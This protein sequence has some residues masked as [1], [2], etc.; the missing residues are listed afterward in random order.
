MRR[1]SAILI[2]LLVLAV[3]AQAA[4]NRL[5]DLASTESVLRWINTYRA[6]PEPA[7]VPDAIKALSRFGAFKEPEQ[8]GAYVGF[9]AG[10][11]AANPDKA[12]A[13]I[14]KML[15]LPPGDQWVIVRAIAYSGHPEW[16]NL[17]RRFAG[18]LPARKVMIDKYL[19]GSLPTL[20]QYTPEPYVST[21][22]SMKNKITGAEL[23]KRFILEPS[24]E[25]LD[26]YWGHYFAT[27]QARPITRIIDM[28]PMAR[29]NDSVERLTVGSMAKFTLASNATRDPELLEILKQAK[30][31]RPKEIVTQL[32]EVIDAAETVET[33]RLRKEAMAA[34]EELRR[35]GPGSRRNIS[36]AGQVGQGALALGCIAAA[37]TGHIE[38]GL[39]CVIGGGVSSAALSAWEKQQ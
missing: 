31:H 3:P 17:L 19:A 21:W 28:L 33:A 24:P 12:E 4:F 9:L 37:A 1:A 15:P 6:K 27:G 29:D 30:E 18:R 7:G 8:A 38:L 26:T 5:I 11:V 10:V 16:R 35:K 36:I 14:S 13:M 20:Y 23:P 22:A 39:P 25:L 32:T 2:A 34:I